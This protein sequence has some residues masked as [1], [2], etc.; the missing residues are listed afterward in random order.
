MVCACACVCVCVCVCRGGVCVGRG[1]AERTSVLGQMDKQTKSTSSRAEKYQRT[2]LVGKAGRHDLGFS[3]LF[4]GLGLAV[5]EPPDHHRQ[6]VPHVLCW[7]IEDDDRLLEEDF[8]IT[9]SS[10]LRGKVLLRQHLTMTQKNISSC[11][12]DLAKRADGGCLDWFIIIK[13]TSRF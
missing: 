12:S 13:G 4:L 9:E 10:H 3:A 1:G 2:C 7:E 8:K 6:D 5:Q 11:L